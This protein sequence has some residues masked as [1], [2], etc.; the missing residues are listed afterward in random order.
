MF[1]L[2]NAATT[3]MFDDV[4]EKASSF[5]T[6]SFYNPSAVYSPA[7]K[8]KRE[9][10]ESKKVLLNALMVDDGDLIFTGSATEANNTVIFSQKL[11]QG[12]K[13]V[14]GA[15]EHPSVL[16]CAKELALKGYD[17]E[18]IPLNKTGCVDIEKYKNII[19]KV[20]LHSLV[21]NT[22]AMKRGQL[23]QL[24]NWLSW[25]ENITKMLF[26]IVMVFRLL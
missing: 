20:M 16:E 22:L 18:F 2:D 26:F 7:V 8:V 24:Q 25:L 4:C 21:F 11:I 10:I 3:K 23:I 1:Y 14:F 17:V 6:E 19:E 12:K 15:G 9:V 5:L 13:Y